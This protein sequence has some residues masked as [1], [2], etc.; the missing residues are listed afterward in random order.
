MRLFGTG[1][2]SGERGVIFKFFAASGRE[3]FNWIQLNLKLVSGFSEGLMGIL[4]KISDFAKKVLELE[5]GIS[6]NTLARIN[7]RKNKFFAKII[8]RAEKF[9]F[10]DGQPSS[11][12]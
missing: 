5:L 2:Y 11:E 10:Q 3:K 8:A 1:H 7:L 6:S 4:C 12:R 9:D